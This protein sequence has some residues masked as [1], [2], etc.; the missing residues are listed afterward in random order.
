MNLIKLQDD[1]YIPDNF[2]ENHKYFADAEGEKRYT[3]ITTVLGTLAKPMLIPWA[4]RMA[5][6]Y[7]DAYIHSKNWLTLDAIDWPKLLEEA[8]TAH[9]KKKEKAGEH[10]TSMHALCEA[11][12]LGCIKGS[13]SPDVGLLSSEYEPIRPFIEW[14][15]ANVEKFLF[16]E[17]A[18]HSKSLFLAGT[19]DFG[20]VMKD[21]KRR[22]GDLKTGS[23]IYYEA[24][25]QCE[26][27]QLLAE[28][29]GDE[30]YHGSVI[31]LMGKDGS[32]QIQE[33]ER[34]E[35][36]E[37]AFFGLYKAYRGSQTFIRPKK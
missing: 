2:A 29:E 17:R 37:D 15:V 19:I 5:T 1:L 14:A 11:W 3:G 13:G 6:E 8:R 27:Y 28:E 18:V 20:A 12:I 4:A 35:I 34:G 10:G 9:T 24:I 21:G 23:G 25:L 32:F 30:K 36:D 16:A 22:I 31:V 26:A 7:I 33:R